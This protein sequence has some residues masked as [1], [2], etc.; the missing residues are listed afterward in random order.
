VL[1]PDAPK[2][3]TLRL[4][5]YCRVSGRINRMG[6][7]SSLSTAILFVSPVSLHKISLAKRELCF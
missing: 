4:Q 2:F 7:T 1:I 5:K 6:K 3:L